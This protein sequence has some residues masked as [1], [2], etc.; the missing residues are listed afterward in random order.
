MNTAIEK[1]SL[2]FDRH[3]KARQ[4]AWFVALWCGGLFTVMACAY[5]I[6]WLMKN[7]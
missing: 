6:K 3:P 2:W 5:P 7:M 4:W 1:I